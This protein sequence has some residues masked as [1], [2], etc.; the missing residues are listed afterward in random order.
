MKGYWIV[1]G[2]PV[3]D[4]EAREKYGAL[5]APIAKKYQA[6]V[7]SEGSSLDLREGEGIA[8]VLIVEFPSID[9]A[10]ACYADPEYADAMAYALAASQRTLL[11]LEG[12]I[13]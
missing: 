7:V 1:L 6:R 11:I 5:W 8:R 4:L 10:R 13:A 2:G 12:E 3:T 9:L